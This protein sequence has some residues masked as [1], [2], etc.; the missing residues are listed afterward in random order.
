MENK[1]NIFDFAGMVL[2]IFGFSMMFMMVFTVICGEDARGFSSMFALGKQG[3]PVAVM[4]QF[5]F[6]A[7]LIVL[8]RWV[9]F[10]DFLIKKSSMTIRTIGMLLTVLLISA[11]FIIAF[12]WF[13]V[14]MWKPWFLFFIDFGISTGISLIVVSLKEKIE[15]KKMEE[16]LKRLREEWKV[17]NNE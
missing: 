12:G 10:T 9:F 3:V 15:N 6:M 7:V 17:E 4:A 14:N 13:P 8:T 5:L 1:K 2:I 16:G 11:G